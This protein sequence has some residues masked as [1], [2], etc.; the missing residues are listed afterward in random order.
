[1]YLILDDIFAAE[2]SSGNMWLKRPVSKYL[3][4]TR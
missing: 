3:L 2:S 4:V 1:M